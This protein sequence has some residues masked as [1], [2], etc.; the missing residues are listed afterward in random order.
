MPI[1]ASACA[2]WPPTFDSLRPPVSGLLAPTE[3]RPPLGAV[4]PPRVPGA[5]T[6]LFSG[7]SGSAFGGTSAKTIASVSARPPQRDQPL[8]NGSSLTDR[9]L[10]LT[11]RIFFIG[12]LHVQAGRPCDARRL[13]LDRADSAPL[14]DCTGASL[15]SGDDIHSNT[16]Y[17]PIRDAVDTCVPTTSM[18]IW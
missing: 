6:S 14:L 7:P 17:C 8:G 10:M 18:S 15:P 2:A 4:V 1:L 11:R 3:R 12:S 9:S 16:S 13:D 5:M